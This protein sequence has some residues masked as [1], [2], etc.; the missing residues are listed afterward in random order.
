MINI[1]KYLKIFQNNFNEAV[2]NI[3]NN[4]ARLDKVFGEILIRIGSNE[5]RLNA[6]EKENE[7]LKADIKEMKRQYNG[8]I[9]R[10]DYAHIFLP[11]E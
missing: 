4:F 5:T 6:L 2:I 1:T 3:N 10:S 7:L 11:I 8:H 9:H